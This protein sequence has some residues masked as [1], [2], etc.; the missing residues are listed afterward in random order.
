LIEGRLGIIK[1]L[2]NA[3]IKMA[4][5]AW[6]ELYLSREGEAYLSLGTKILC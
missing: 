5:R 4:G 3:G 2:K 1:L 6:E